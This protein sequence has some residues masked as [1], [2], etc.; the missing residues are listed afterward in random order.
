[1]NG[2][3][4]RVAAVT[5]VAV[6]GSA[7]ALGLAGN[8][9]S[10]DGCLPVR[11][12]LEADGGDTE[13]E[14]MTGRIHGA[15]EYTFQGFQPS[16]NNPDVIYLEGRSVV[17]TPTGEIRFVENSAAAVGNQRGTNNATLMTVTG[18]TG[19][20]EGASGYIAL[21]GFFHTDDSVGSFDYRGEVCL[22]G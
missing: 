10:R 2:Q 9:S 8:A 15:Y 20:W 13:P 17:S 3:L 4:A 5:A 21:F 18:G 7:L 22:G 16:G 6:V 1:V 12:H 19:A 11:G 14:R